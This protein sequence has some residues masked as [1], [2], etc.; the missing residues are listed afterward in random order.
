MWT[1]PSP[2]ECELLA[3]PPSQ[4]VYRIEKLVIGREKNPV[5]FSVLITPSNRVTYSISV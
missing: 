5:S 1:F 4:P 3:C 2:S